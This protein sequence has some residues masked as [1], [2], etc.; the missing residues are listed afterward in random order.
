M[1]M[2]ELG[3]RSTGTSPG[4]GATAEAS[5]ESRGATP[6]AASGS[7]NGAGWCREMRRDIKNV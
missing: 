3:P 5:V 1:L 4:D 2:E 6:S 7:S